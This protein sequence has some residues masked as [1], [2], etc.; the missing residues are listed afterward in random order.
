MTR[1]KGCRVMVERK[2]LTLDPVAP[3]PEVGR[4][5]AALQ[6]ARGRTLRDLDGVTDE[7]IDRRP[8]EGANSIGTVLYHI[9]AI[10]TDWLFEEI[11]GAEASPWPQ[12]LFP[13]AVRE[14]DGRLT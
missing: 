2:R 9:A 8:F 12:D 4:W 11:L 13:F 6:D 14:E 7:E 10:E 5:L 1:G 3:D